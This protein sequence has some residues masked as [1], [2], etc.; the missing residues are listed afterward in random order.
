M[1]IDFLMAAHLNNKF[2]NINNNINK[3]SITTINN[4]VNK[5]DLL[6]TIYFTS[7]DNWIFFYWIYILSYFY[8]RTM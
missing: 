8:Q 2:S 3:L 7:S 1:S 6:Y 4:N 5:L